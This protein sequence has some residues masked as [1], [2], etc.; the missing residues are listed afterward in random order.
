MCVH[1]L[2]QDI[3][4]LDKKKEVDQINRLRSSNMK[5]DISTSF[6]AIELEYSDIFFMDPIPNND[7][8]LNR[9]IKNSNLL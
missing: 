9:T 8:N 6:S 2:I 5:N 7:K 3:S 1:G 4:C